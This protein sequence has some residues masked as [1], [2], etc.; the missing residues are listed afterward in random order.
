VLIDPLVEREDRVRHADRLIE[1]LALLA[2]T[3]RMSVV[4]RLRMAS[5]IEVPAL[6][7]AMVVSVV[8]VLDEPA[9]ALGLRLIRPDRQTPRQ[10]SA[11]PR[12]QARRVDH[13]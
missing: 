4:R 5:R 10:F 12:I 9:A 13:R 1:W 2:S 8:A 7:D 3:G 6:I 11:I